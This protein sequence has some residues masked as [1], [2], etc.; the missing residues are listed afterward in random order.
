MT[1]LE[2]IFVALPLDCPETLRG[3]TKPL[4]KHLLR[5]LNSETVEESEDGGLSIFLK[6][7]GCLTTDSSGQTKN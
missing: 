3:K 6:L 4:L 1:E 5:Y 2:Q 7:Y